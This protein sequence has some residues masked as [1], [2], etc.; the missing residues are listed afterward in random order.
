MT[1]RTRELT[2]PPP[3][4]CLRMRVYAMTRRLGGLAGSAGALACLAAVAWL[5]F[6]F[7]V[8]GPEQPAGSAEAPTVPA[9]PPVSRDYPHPPAIAK[10][11]QSSPLGM[12]SALG[13]PRQVAAAYLSA[14]NVMADRDPGCRLDW[15]VLA[16]IGRVES[17]HARGGALLADGTTITPILGPRLDGTLAGTAAIRDTTEGRYDGDAE[18]ERA[19]GPMQ[20]LPGTWLNFGQDGNNDG[21]RDP[22]N[23]HDAALASA[24]YLCAG[25]RDLS[26]RT[27]LEQAVFSY[28]PSWSYVRA[29]LAWAD[30]Y[31]EGRREVSDSL[32]ALAGGNS[33]A[34]RMAVGGRTRQPNP[35]ASGKPSSSSPTSSVSST[36]ATPA[37]HSTTTG[38]PPATTSGQPPTST[39]D[40]DPTDMSEQPEAPPSCPPTTPPSESSEPSTTTEPSPSTEPTT[41]E[42][43]PSAEPTTTPPTSS[44]PGPD[45][46]CAGTGQD[47]GPT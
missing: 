5:A 46:P 40:G 12:M 1:S 14:E 7:T 33:W 19:V 4:T 45:E 9:H 16:G 39:A 21:N 2:G 20:F 38:A 28:N 25:D 41:T 42:P 34:N 47:A 31:A 29:V 30:A 36:T 24:T 35:P 22:H 44:E 15:S 37:P 11:T 10:G 3:T 18:Y 32:V 43:S 27:Q 13:L 6:G 17:G 26:E 8:R 23:I